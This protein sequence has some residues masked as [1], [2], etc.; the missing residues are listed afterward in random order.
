MN[1]Q[2]RKDKR[3]RKQQQT[4]THIRNNKNGRESFWWLKTDRLTNRQTETETEGQ[5]KR[6]GF[7]SCTLRSN[8]AVNTR[9][10]FWC[11]FMHIYQSLCDIYLLLLY[12]KHVGG[13]GRKKNKSLIPLEKEK[14]ITL[15]KDRKKR[16]EKKRERNLNQWPTPT[17]RQ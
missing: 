2:K 14:K 17:M 13:G 4:H 8:L 7:E 10:F 6:E 16:V 11:I 1:K 12:V 15:R 3:R 5:R 9:L